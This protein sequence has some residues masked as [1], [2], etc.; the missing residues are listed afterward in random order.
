MCFYEN[1]D[2]RTEYFVQKPQ[3]QNSF[4]YDHVLGAHW[5]SVINHYGFNQA[6]AYLSHS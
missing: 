1:K 6:V 3:T 4:I 2:G 5:G